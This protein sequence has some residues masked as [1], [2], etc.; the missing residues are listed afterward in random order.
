MIVLNA[1]MAANAVQKKRVA[2]ALTVNVKIAS[3]LTMIVAIAA[4]AMIANK[5]HLCH[6]NLFFF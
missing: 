1:V 2:V 5:L 6:L 3:A 4:N